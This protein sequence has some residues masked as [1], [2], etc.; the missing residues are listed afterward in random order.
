MPA[1]QTAVASRLTVP[2]NPLARLVDTQ[3]RPFLTQLDRVSGGIFLDAFMNPGIDGE[4]GEERASTDEECLKVGFAFRM[5]A[6]IDVLQ[7]VAPQLIKWLIRC[8]AE[9]DC[10]RV[11]IQNLDAPAITIVR[12]KV[13][14]GA[15]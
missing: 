3:M 1:S 13:K 15:A 7:P 5:D 6:T 11:G 14:A 12:R 2:P 9:I 4:L 10:A 8:A